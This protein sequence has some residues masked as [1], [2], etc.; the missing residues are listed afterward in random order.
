MEN[1]PYGLG[2]SL[3]GKAHL[4]WLAVLAGGV[5]LLSVSYRLCDPKERRTLLKKLTAL[6]LSLHIIA[7]AILLVT[8]QYT[9]N[10]IPL[11]LCNLAVFAE[12]IYAR[13]RNPLLG[14]FCYCLFMPGALMALI[15]PDW[16]SLPLLNLFCIRNFAVHGLL[17]GIP[18][19]MAAGGD[20]RPDPKNLRYCFA[21]GVAMCVPMYVIDKALDVNF[22]FLNWPS[23]GSPLELFAKWFGIPGY[24]LGLPVM[25]AAVW[26]VLYLPV[27][28]TQKKRV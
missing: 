28:L 20:L 21:I 26:L 27:L 19:A 24:L 15:F 6:T 4:V 10:Y 16:V 2:F 25:T 3:F 9:P 12:F 14:E 11:D 1:I 13:W 7:D 22:F 17:I 23:P 5:L 8:G 18:V